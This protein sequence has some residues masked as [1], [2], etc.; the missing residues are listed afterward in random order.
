MRAGDA[1]G[2][3]RIVPAADV[4]RRYAEVSGDFNPVHLD[5]E[6]AEA[7]GLPGVIL[8]GLWTMA[9]LARVDLAAAGGDPARLERL[10]V[11]FR[12]AGLPEREIAVAATVRDVRDGRA[13]VEH[14][15]RQDRRRLVRRARAEI[16][17]DPGA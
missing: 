13:L 6:Y 3:E 2:P 1:I 8:H 16:A 7:A 17:L 10:S 9:Q 14:D 11:E 15:V 4:P 5:P 12:S